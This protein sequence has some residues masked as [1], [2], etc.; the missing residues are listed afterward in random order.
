MKLWKPKSTARL[1]PFEMLALCRLVGCVKA[2]DKGCLDVEGVKPSGL[3]VLIRLG[4]EPVK[5]N[6]NDK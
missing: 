2:G 1:N 6:V 5:P 4:F 3:L